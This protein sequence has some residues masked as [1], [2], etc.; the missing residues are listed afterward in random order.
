LSRFTIRRQYRV[1]QES[2]ST[3]LLDE[4]GKNDR[5]EIDLDELGSVEENGDLIGQ[6]DETFRCCSDV[7]LDRVNVQ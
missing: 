1:H 6:R 7:D 2:Q 4:T 5:G 3:G